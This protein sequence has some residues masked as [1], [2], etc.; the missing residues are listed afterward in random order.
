MA[1]PERGF[2]FDLDGTLV[3]TM[4]THFRAWTEIATRHG[5]RFP[6]DR[7]YSLGGVPTA[8][9]AGLLISEAGLTLD[10]IAI[11]R[12][13]EQ[14]YYD[15][16]T[17]G[18]AIK[19]IDVVLELARQHRNE[20]P[21]AVASGSVRRLVE[22]TLAVLGISDWFAATVAAEDTA[23]HKPE[24]DV[25][26]EAARRIGVDPAHCLV[27]EDTDIGLEAAH[28]AG[29]AAVDVR[30]LLLPTRNPQEVPNLPR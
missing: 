8:K 2:I 15:S 27:Y 20:G 21:M 1:N 4:P 26:L 18:A 25:F 13:K 9:I 10:P 29:M 5:L 22:R 6:E 16:L 30:R 3:D 28:R 12:E 11:A 19:P 14:A 7:F 23:R 17:N 24:P